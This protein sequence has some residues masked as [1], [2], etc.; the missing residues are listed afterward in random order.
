VHHRVGA[1][2]GKEFRDRG[3]IVNSRPHQRHAWWHRLLV[4]GREIIKEFTPFTD[5][6]KST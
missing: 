4:A 3:T 5:R 2:I 6:W 1:V